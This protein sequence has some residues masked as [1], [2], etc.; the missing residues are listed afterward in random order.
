MP[1]DTSIILQQAIAAH[2]LGDFNQAEK[3]YLSILE[4]EAQH[5]DANHNLGL[6][7]I[8]LEQP[9]TALPLLQKA[10]QEHPGIEQ[11]WI[12][13]FEALVAAGKARE[14][15][16]IL[17]AGKENDLQKHIVD[18]LEA[19]VIRTET[20]RE[21]RPKKEPPE[22]RI[23]HLAGLYEIGLQ[24]Q[25]IK[26]AQHLLEDF[27]NSA[28]LYNMLGTAQLDLREYDQARASY[29]TAITL[30][31][32]FALP[33]VNLGV[34]LSLQGYFDAAIAQYQDSLKIQPDDIKAMIYIGNA[35]Q[36]KGDFAEAIVS[37]DRAIAH[38]ADCA[39]A[40]NN[41]GNAFENQGNLEAAITS[42]A[43][44]LALDPENKTTENNL[45]RARQALATKR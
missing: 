32:T 23:Q 8:S 14:A 16:A 42:Y 43:Q 44:A 11:Y 27:P 39:E 22:L 20:A 6:L 33:R 45:A 13:Y 41:L 21:R 37:Y 30:D 26:D 40:H 29:E 28:L 4:I 38:E 31:P 25:M 12:S 10:L 34:T 2:K 36:S 5:P 19:I 15:R 18:R 1:S 9:L 3:H 24:Q 17:E 7:Y 35:L